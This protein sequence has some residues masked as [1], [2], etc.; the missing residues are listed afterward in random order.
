MLNSKFVVIDFSEDNITISA[1]GQFTKTINISK[2]S[3]VP[4]GIM[5]QSLN[6]ASINGT[7]VSY[8]NIYRSRILENS[9]E[10]CIKNNATSGS[11]KVKITFSVLYE[12]V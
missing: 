7:L 11:A 3:Y 5:S 9:A 1:S 2:D 6:N 10:I 4:I 8:C 12:K